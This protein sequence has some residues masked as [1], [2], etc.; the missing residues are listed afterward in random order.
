MEV[1]KIVVTVIFVIAC[2]ALSA[3]VLAQEGKSAGLS[4]S[5]SGL[6]DTYWG[7]NRSRS[8]EGGLLKATIILSVIFFVFSIILNVL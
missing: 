7:K 5:I 8:R 2:F 6:A 1:L 4:G 3:C